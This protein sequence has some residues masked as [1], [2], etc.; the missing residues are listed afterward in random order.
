MSV[1][2][3][4]EMMV[5]SSGFDYAKLIGEW[6]GYDV[7]R[8]MLKDRYRKTGNPVMILA[9]QDGRCRYCDYEETFR[10]YDAIYA[11]NNLII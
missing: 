5:K 3:Q 2:V 8:L 6:E 1:P 7:Y 4:I 10:I 11:T 9:D